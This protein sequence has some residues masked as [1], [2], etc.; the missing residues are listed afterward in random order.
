MTCQLLSLFLLVLIAE[1]IRSFEIDYAAL[2]MVALSGTCLNLY[3]GVPIEDM[4]AG[5]IVWGLA[6]LLTRWA[7]GRRAI[8]QGDL[9]LLPAIGLLAGVRASLTACAI[10]ALLSLVTAQS[11]RV[12]RSRPQNRR[13]FSIFPAALPGTLTVFAV[14]MAR[15][16]GVDVKFAEVVF[17]I[18]ALSEV[19]AFL[20][21]A[22][23]RW[24]VL[25]MVSGSVLAL[26]WMIRD[27]W[28]MARRGADG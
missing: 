5:G 4:I 13:Q 10:F 15:I 22:A 20:R 23:S 12:A 26:V 2:A 27:R 19:N 24:G 14:F 7:F 18:P 11:Y 1:D 17:S 9:W 25:V 8:G 28:R 16:A 6:G 21:S 3:L